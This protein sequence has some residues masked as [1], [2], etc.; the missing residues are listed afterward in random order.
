MAK[1]FRQ[2]WLGLSE[3][4]SR[5]YRGVVG[6]VLVT[7]NSPNSESLRRVGPCLTTCGG[8]FVRHPGP[9]YLW[10]WSLHAGWGLTA[11]RK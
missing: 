5:R 1:G 9:F 11:V 6:P 7:S 10:G 8:S 3:S 4:G 2:L